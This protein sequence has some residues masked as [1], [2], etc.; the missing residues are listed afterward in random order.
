LAPI[1]LLPPDFFFPPVFFLLDFLAADFL[2]LGFP[3]E[4]DARLACAEVWRPLPLSIG[5]TVSSE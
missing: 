4:A 2:A 3:D 5:T 1:F